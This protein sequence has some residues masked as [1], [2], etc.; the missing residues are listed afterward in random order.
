VIDE[1]ARK[2]EDASS[3]T[4][5]QM[6]LSH[7][8]G[9]HSLL[10]QAV[11]A[12]Q[13]SEDAESPPDTV[14]G[15]CGGGDGSFWAIK[16]VDRQPRRKLPGVQAVREGFNQGGHGAPTRGVGTTGEK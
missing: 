9:S 2:S 7:S 11:A 13:A 8:Q 3:P 14:A 6:N 5:A 15:H 12:K 1:N 10:A 4:S 16:I